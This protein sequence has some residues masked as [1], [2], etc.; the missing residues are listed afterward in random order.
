M[1][2][3]GALEVLA[4]WD[5][6]WTKFE[7]ASMQLPLEAFCRRIELERPAWIPGLLD[8]LSDVDINLQLADEMISPVR[9]ACCN[10]CHAFAPMQTDWVQAD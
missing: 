5:P 1:T 2:A 9:A 3:D 6:E 7:K 10:P 4:R 8:A